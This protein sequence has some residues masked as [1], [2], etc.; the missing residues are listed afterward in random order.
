MTDLSTITTVELIEEIKRREECGVICTCTTLDQDREGRRTMWWGGKF[1]VL[2]MA[3][4]A[5]K[6]IEQDLINDAVEGKEQP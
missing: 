1:T 6:G 2:G 5:Q 4:F 3:R